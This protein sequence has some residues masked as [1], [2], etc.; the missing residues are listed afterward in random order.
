MKI[1][2][3]FSVCFPWMEDAE[4][5]CSC[6]RI[7]WWKTI[8]YFIFLFQQ[9]PLRWQHFTW[10]NSVTRHCFL[11]LNCCLLAKFWMAFIY[12]KY[13]RV[14]GK[15]QLSVYHTPQYP[16][17]WHVP[18]SSHHLLGPSC[19]NTIACFFDICW[20]DLYHQIMQLCLIASFILVVAFTNAIIT[21]V[22][23]MTDKHRIS[24]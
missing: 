3:V 2:L 13:W 11:E 1:S 23:G 12:G 15:R 24:L 14:S 10:Q 5:M 22:V 6:S 20:F 8:I 21:T 18:I 16:L 17:K 9:S 4:Q 7:G 19:N